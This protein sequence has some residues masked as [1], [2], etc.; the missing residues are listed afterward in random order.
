MPEGA[1]V[2]IFKL[3]SAGDVAG[4]VAL[5]AADPA[6]AAARNSQGLSALLFSLYSGQAGMT[7]AIRPLLA[8]DLAEAA[9]L[10]E[11]A[12]VEELLLTQADGQDA[13]SADG[14]TVLQLACYFGHPETAM[15]LIRHGADIE[16]VS[17]NPMQ[18]R[19]LHAA[20]AADNNEAIEALLSAGAD[21]NAI[22]QAGFVA[23]HACAQNGNALGLKLLLEHGA[24]PMLA[25][26][27]GKTAADFAAEAGHAELASTLAT[28]L[29]SGAPDPEA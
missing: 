2:E 12:R 28:A 7:E 11:S 9:A 23:L 14:F 10:G 26:D 6:L 17:N 1:Q 4:L 27:A 19:P 20:A 25:N 5:L 13:R 3:I 8:P 24:D 15:L 22:Q 18:I 16:A 21:P 29:E